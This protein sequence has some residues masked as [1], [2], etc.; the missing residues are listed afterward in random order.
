MT[1]TIAY[2]AGAG[3]A[4]CYG[5]ATVLEQVGARR[6][7]EVKKF[8]PKY[9]VKLFSQLPYLIGTLLD[10]IGWLMSLIA[11][12]QLPLFLAQSFIAASL[13]VSGIIDR[14]Y[15]HTKIS[16]KEKLAMGIISAGLLMLTLTAVPHGSTL[17]SHG[18]RD[19]LI[20]A[21]VFLAA[22]GV[23]LINFGL[24]KKDTTLMVVFAGLAFGG[25]NIAARVTRVSHFGIHVLFEPLVLALISYG[26]VGTMLFSISLQRDNISR[27]NATLFATE[28]VVPSILGI[29]FLN[30]KVRPGFVGV[31]ALGLLTVVGGTVLMGIAGVQQ[32]RKLLSTRGVSL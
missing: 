10:T 17:P 1:H 4:V 12:R 22:A 23:L 29:F 13:V 21:P 24:A 5:V 26:I 7:A 25:T 27:I 20:I 2:L 28:V 11:V 15:L 8:H 32:K 31:A 3:S 16:N 19:L 30:D 9:L 18:F 6:S 14:Y